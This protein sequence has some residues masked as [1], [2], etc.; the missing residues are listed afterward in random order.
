VA[1]GGTLV[2][3]LLPFQ[4]TAGV[5]VERSKGAWRIPFVC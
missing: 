4:T 2:R 1:E 5:P 3:A